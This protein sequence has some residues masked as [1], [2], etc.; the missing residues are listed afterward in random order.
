MADRLGIVDYTSFPTGGAAASDDFLQRLSI[1]ENQQ[2]L[3]RR[4]SHTPGH[5]GKSAKSAAPQGPQ[6]FERRAHH[7][8]AKPHGRT[9]SGSILKPRGA[10]RQHGRRITF[11]PEVVTRVEDCAEGVDRKNIPCLAFG[12]V[13]PYTPMEEKIVGTRQKN[14]GS[15]KALK[16]SRSTA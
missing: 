14:I 6:D 3:E 1:L 12:G 5:A 15:G 9:L 13:N 2:E 16:A 7:N 11:H 10:R 4:A 8:S